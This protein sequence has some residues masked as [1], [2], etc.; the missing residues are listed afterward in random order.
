MHN[1]LDHTDKRYAQGGFTMLHVP[2]Y[3]R[4]PNDLAFYDLI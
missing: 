4:V 3:F 2:R 1:D